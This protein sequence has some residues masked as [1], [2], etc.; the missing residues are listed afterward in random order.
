VLTS[1]MQKASIS[2]S[3][4]RLSEV[5]S[6]LTYA[7]D[8]TEGQPEG[9]AIRSCMI[10]MR[11][12][13]L[14]GLSDDDQSALYYA[15]LLKDL[16]CSSNAA[17]MCWL[18]KADDRQIKRDVKLIDW[19]KMVRNG[20]FA[21]KNANAGASWFE[22][23]KSVIEMAK[24]GPDEGRELIQVRCERGADITRMLGFPD[25]TA[26]A[27][28]GLDEHWNGNGHP[29]GLKGEQIPLLGR[30]CCIAQTAE[31]FAA[32]YGFRHALQIIKR[33]SGTW[34]DPEL[35]DAIY[36]TRHDTGFW[37]QIKQDTIDQQVRLVEPIDKVR[38]VNS[39]MLGRIALAFSQVVDAKSPWTYRHSEGV[40]IISYGIAQTLNLP[41]EKQNEIR[42]AGL[43]HDIGK[44][45]VSN[46]ILDKPAKLNDE[47]Y[48]QM[49]AHTTY[50]HKILGRV[51]CFKAFADYASAHHERVD[52]KGYH[53][54]LKD[55]RLPIEARILA[56]AD[57]TEAL[58]AKRPYRDSMPSERIIDILQ[59]DIGKAFDGRCV[60]A[61][62]DYADGTSLFDMLKTQSNN[63]QVNGF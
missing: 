44:L 60:E 34:F 37:E 33:R 30:I 15:L 5:I 43:L 16:G 46:L 52:G 41:V 25:A 49:K 1:T 11:I 40:S 3:E 61:L 27:I 47:E 54:G 62:L 26:E 17:K 10:G 22:K 55:E 50:T 2:T 24:R 45:G 28:L 35:V 53:R 13:R 18:F 63:V 20:M 58:A 19:T 9:H 8:I 4:L 57:V 23:I 36:A 31:V 14:I 21:L 6:A 12:A 56:V 59:G 7:L 48:E 29:L 51:S 32:K 39:E 42:L 38:L